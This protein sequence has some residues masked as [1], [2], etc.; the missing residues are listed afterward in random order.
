MSALAAKG[1]QGCGEFYEKENALYHA[2]YAVAC[3][4]MPDNSGRLWWT[5]YEVF[6]ETGEILGPDL[7]AVDAR[8]G[9]PPRAWT[10]DELAQMRPQARGRKRHKRR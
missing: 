4:E 1:V 10:K 3:A 9:G 8:F 7:T 6:P 5:G 2:D